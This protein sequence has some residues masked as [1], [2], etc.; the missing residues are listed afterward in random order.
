MNRKFRLDTRRQ[1]SKLFFLICFLT[2]IGCSPMDEERRLI[3]NNLKDP[4]STKFRNEK[5]GKEGHVCGEFNSKNSYGA[6]AGYK[7]YIAKKPQ[8]YYIEDGNFGG[9]DVFNISLFVGDRDNNYKYAFKHVWE[10]YC[11]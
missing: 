7:K 4:E 11:S 1:A 6:Y 10:R 2:L 3:T 8:N 9:L 5:K